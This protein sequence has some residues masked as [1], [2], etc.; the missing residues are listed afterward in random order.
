MGIFC[1]YLHRRKIHPHPYGKTPAPHIGGTSFGVWK[2]DEG[3]ISK[4]CKI[5]IGSS[6]VVARL[7]MCSN[8]MA[9]EDIRGPKSFGDTLK[10]VYLM[11]ERIGVWTNQGRIYWRDQQASIV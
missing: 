1:H 5:H 7:A 9:I 3:T 10:R 2:V 6:I 8:A 4:W 11:K